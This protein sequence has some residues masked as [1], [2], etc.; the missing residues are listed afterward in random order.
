MS[1]LSYLS[2]LRLVTV[3]PLPSCSPTSNASAL[4]GRT[5][6]GQTCLGS[7]EVSAPLSADDFADVARALVAEYESAELV[8]PLAA[9][10]NAQ[11]EAMRE[12][13]GKTT[14]QACDLPHALEGIA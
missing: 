3:S 14:L 2:D 13:Y 9:T 4:V 12:A 5:A 11:R 8:S 6:N 1:S 10:F 7:I